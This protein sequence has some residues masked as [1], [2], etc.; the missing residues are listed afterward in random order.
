MRRGPIAAG[1]LGNPIPG[2]VKIAAVPHLDAL[3]LCQQQ[4]VVD[5]R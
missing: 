4:G 2:L 1:G 3:L 5:L